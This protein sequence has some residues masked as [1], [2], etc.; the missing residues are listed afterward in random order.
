MHESYR[1]YG[2]KLVDEKDIGTFHKI[3]NDTVKKGF[4]VKGRVWLLASNS[5]LINE[6]FCIFVLWIQLMF[7][8]DYEY[9]GL[10]TAKEKCASSL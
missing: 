5:E 7:I 9:F 10:L 6:S 3:V 4:E 8:C 2:D 1:V